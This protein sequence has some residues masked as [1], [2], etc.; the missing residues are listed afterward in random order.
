LES[1][2]K[3]ITLNYKEDYGKKGGRVEDEDA[4]R[5]GKIYFIMDEWAWK[6]MGSGSESDFS[7]CRLVCFLF[8]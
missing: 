2:G 4:G 1:K 7:F 5:N 3:Y 6:E 8:W